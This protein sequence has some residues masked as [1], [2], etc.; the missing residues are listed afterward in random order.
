[1]AI[2]IDF[3]TSNTLITRWNAAKNEPEVLALDRLSQQLINNPPLIPSQIY[4]ANA[5]KPEV[6]LGQAVGDRGLD[7]S[8]DQRLYRNF[9]R[10]IG[11]KTQGF[12]PELE[13]QQLSFE[14]LGTWFLKDIFRQ[15]Q[16][17]EGNIDSLVLTVPVDSFE[18]YRSWLTDVCADLPYIDKIQLL[19]EP[20]AAAL[21]YGA[22]ADDLKQVLVVDF[23]GGTIDFSLVE[24]NLSKGQ[25]KP[26]GFIMRWANKSYADSKTQKARTAKVV[27]KA[28]KNLGGSDLDNWLFDYFEKQ[29]NLPQDALS[30]RLIERLKIKLS[31]KNKASEVYY[32][33]ETFESVELNLERSEFE[34]ILQEQG[35]IEQLDELMSQVLQQARRNGGWEG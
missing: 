11:S 16:Q 21:G 8:K 14:K 13:G 19:D 34:E 28:G 1:M 9:K 7:S 33:A 26:T 30:L 5:A 32:N 35:F 31:E 12:L 2:A 22:L 27:A 25:S 17:Q 18:A 15:V 29:Q 10:G 6:I 20:T 24:L 3:G 23:G 4:V